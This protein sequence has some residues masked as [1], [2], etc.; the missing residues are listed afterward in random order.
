MSEDYD[1]L[2]Y[3]K[4]SEEPDTRID[5]VQ[6]F[7]LIASQWGIFISLSY[8]GSVSSQINGMILLICSIMA[9]AFAWMYPPY[10]AALV[11]SARIYLKATVYHGTFFTEKQ[12]EV[13][14]APKVVACMDE[15]DIT[16]Y[17]DDLEYA[18]LF[19]TV[20]I[21]NLTDTEIDDEIKKAFNNRYLK[22]IEEYKQKHNG[23]KKWY[24]K[25]YQKKV[26]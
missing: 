10:K 17:E 7:V 1:I 3:I 20:G 8:L 15:N 9:M 14:D 13:V 23:D 18:E 22:S 6:T 11:A 24:Q 26:K 19:K 5:D 16:E 2:D 4:Q 25:I 12:Y 21:T